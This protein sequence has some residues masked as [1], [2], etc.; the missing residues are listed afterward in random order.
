MPL[1]DYFL[2][3]TKS[4]GPNTS[5][6]NSS[7]ETIRPSTTLTDAC[8]RFST[9][10]D[11]SGRFPTLTDARLISS[12]IKSQTFRFRLIKKILKLNSLKEAIRPL[13]TPTDASGRFP[14]LTDASGR[15]PTL[16]D[17]RLISATLKAQTFRFR[18]IK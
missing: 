10:L 4:Q 6:L 5:I 3:A 11:A 12:T 18:L 1:H 13:G 7:K 9:L 8:G 2:E 17:A 16:A 15:F 14:T